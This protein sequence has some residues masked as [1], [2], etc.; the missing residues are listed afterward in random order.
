MQSTMGTMQAIANV[1]LTSTPIA[2]TFTNPPGPLAGHVTVIVS[3]HGSAA[4]GDEYEYTDD[5][6]TLGTK[7]VGVFRPC[8]FTALR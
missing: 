6:V 4:G 1:D 7:E 3:G 2:G 5:T 8:S